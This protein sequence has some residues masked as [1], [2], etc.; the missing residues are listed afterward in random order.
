MQ[1][2]ICS[3]AKDIKTFTLNDSYACGV[4]KSAKS[5]T[6]RMPKHPSKQHVREYLMTTILQISSFEKTNFGK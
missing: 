2:N 6:K 5:Q 3:P 1:Q 4:T